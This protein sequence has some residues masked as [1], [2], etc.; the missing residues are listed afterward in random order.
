[1]TDEEALAAAERARPARRATDA[2]GVQALYFGL[3]FLVIGVILF[4]GMLTMLV[5]QLRV[6]LGHGDPGTFTAERVY[7]TNGKGRW[8]KWQ[9]DFVSAEGR[10]RRRDVLL[11]GIGTR[12]LKRGARV[13]A[14]DVG[15]SRDVYP[16]KARYEWIG[17]LVGLFVAGG[18]ML[19]SAI[20]WRSWF[21]TRREA[22]GRHRR[23]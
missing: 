19:I 14:I 17:P 20:G 4:V 18:L 21:R 12:D 15:S 22:G 8:C 5:P 9:G 1:M 11:T 3:L 2:K 13:A 16:R 6:A 10:S 7:C 23:A